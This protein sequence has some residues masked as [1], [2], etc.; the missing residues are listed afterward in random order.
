MSLAIYNLLQQGYL[1]YSSDINTD[2]FNTTHDLELVYGENENM[3]VGFSIEKNN[4]VSK[5]GILT[6]NVQEIVPKLK[7]INSTEVTINIPLNSLVYKNKNLPNGV[8]NVLYIAKYTKNISKETLYT[9][10]NGIISSIE[11]SS[12]N[13]D[14]YAVYNDEILCELNHLDGQINNN[15]SITINIEDL[16]VTKDLHLIVFNDFIKKSID[17]SDKELFGDMSSIYTEIS[18]DDSQYIFN[19]TSSY[20]A[21]SNCN[22]LFAYGTDENPYLHV[23][24]YDNDTY[25]TSSVTIDS[26]P[27]SPISKLQFTKDSS[28]LFVLTKQDPY[29]KIYTISNNTLN[30]GLSIGNELPTQEVADIAVTSNGSSIYLMSANIGTVIRRYTLSGNS[31]TLTSTRTLLDND[32]NIYR[33]MELNEDDSVIAL[34]SIDNGLIYNI[35]NG[36]IS[37]VNTTYIDTNIQIF[38]CFKFKWS[39]TKKYLVVNG[40]MAYYNTILN[41]NV[42]I[43]KKDGD[44]YKYLTTITDASD[45]YD[46][47]SIDFDLED[48]CMVLGGNQLLNSDFRTEYST[49]IRSFNIDNDVFTLQTDYFKDINSEFLDIFNGIGEVTS[50]DVSP[51]QIYI[52]ATSKTQPYLHIFSSSEKYI[53]SYNL[54]QSKIT[55]SISVDFVEDFKT[56]INTI[57][58]SHSYV[59]YTSSNINDIL[60]TNPSLAYS[61][62]RVTKDDD[63]LRVGMYADMNSNLEQDYSNKVAQLHFDTRNLNLFGNLVSAKLSF[64]IDKNTIHKRPRGFL[65]NVSNKLIVT[66][67][68]NNTS[69]YQAVSSSITSEIVSSASLDPYFY[70]TGNKTNYYDAIAIS[71]ESIESSYIDISNINQLGVTSFSLFIDSTYKSSNFSSSEL[72]SNGNIVSYS[73]YKEYDTFNTDYNTIIS[74][75]V[76]TDLNNEIIVSQ[77]TFP[78]FYT[79]TSKVYYHDSASQNIIN[80]TNTLTSSIMP[81]S[82]SKMAVSQDGQ[83]LIYDSGLM[84]QELTRS[85]YNENNTYHKNISRSNL[86]DRKVSDR[87]KLSN[88]NLYVLYEGFA[89]HDSYVWNLSNLTQYNQTDGKVPGFS[90]YSINGNSLSYYTLPTYSA[91]YYNGNFSN[92]SSQLVVLNNLDVPILF[93]L[94]NNTYDKL[95]IKSREYGMSQESSYITNGYFID[96][97][98]NIIFGMS[99]KDNQ[100]FKKNSASA[101]NFTVDVPVSSSNFIHTSN[102]SNH[103]L[104]G[105]IS[106]SEKH[107]KLYKHNYNNDTFELI[108]NPTEII[109]ESISISYRN[110]ILA[111]AHNSVDKIYIYSQSNDSFTKLNTPTSLPL[112]NMK[113]IQLSNDSKYMV[114]T[115]DTSPYMFVYKN[116]SNIY[117]L[118]E[119]DVTPTTEISS[120]GI[121]SV[122]NIGNGDFDVFLPYIYSGSANT[123]Y[124]Y[125][126]NSITDNVEFGYTASTGNRITNPHSINDS[127]YWKDIKWSND[128]SYFYMITMEKTVDGDET[129]GV[130]YFEPSYYT[131]PYTKQSGYAIKELRD[132]VSYYATPSSYKTYDSYDVALNHYP[133]KINSAHKLPEYV[134]T[135]NSGLNM[136]VTIYN[137]EFN[138][139]DDTTQYRYLSR[140]HRIY[141]N[142]ASEITNTQ[143]VEYKFSYD[144][145]YIYGVSEVSPYFTIYNRNSK[146]YNPVYIYSENQL[147]RDYNSDPNPKLNFYKYYPTSSLASI[148]GYKFTNTNNDFVVYGMGISETSDPIEAFSVNTSSYHY[149]FTKIDNYIDTTQLQGKTVI[150]LSY[151]SDDNR[152][153]ALCNDKSNIFL[154]Y[155]TS[156]ETGYV[157]N[158]TINTIPIKSRG[159]YNLADANIS[160]D[161]SYAVLC[162]YGNTNTIHTYQINDE[163][164]VTELDNICNTIDRVTSAD[165]S[166]TGSF[167][168]N[169][170]YNDSFTN[171]TSGKGVLVLSDINGWLEN[172][173]VLLQRYSSSFTTES[174]SLIATSSYNLYQSNVFDYRFNPINNLLNEKFYSFSYDNKL[175]SVVSYKTDCEGNQ[176]TT[177]V[178]IFEY[179][180]NENKWDIYESYKS[181]TSNILSLDYKPTSVSYTKFHPSMPLLICISYG[182]NKGISVYKFKSYFDP[183]DNPTSDVPGIMELVYKGILPSDYNGILVSNIVF[184]NDGKYMILHSSVGKIYGYKITWENKRTPI[185]TELDKGYTEDEIDLGSKYSAFYNRDI[186]NGNQQVA[187]FINDTEFVMPILQS[188]SFY[189]G[190]FDYNGTNIPLQASS[191]KNYIFYIDENDT[192]QLK[193]ETVEPYFINDTLPSYYNNQY[194]S[195][196]INNVSLVD[197]FNTSLNKDYIFHTA[198]YQPNSDLPDIQDAYLVSGSRILYRHKA[199]ENYHI[200]EFPKSNYI[201]LDLEYQPVTEPT[202]SINATSYGYIEYSSSNVNDIFDATSSIDYYIYSQSET[203]K[204]GLSYEGGVYTANVGYISFNT[205]TVAN[206]VSPTKVRLVFDINE[207]SYSYKPKTFPN[208]VDN[209]LNL[210]FYNYPFAIEDIKGLISTINQAH[211]SSYITYIEENN[212]WIRPIVVNTK[213]L[214]SDSSSNIDTQF[215]YPDTE[216][217]YTVGVTDNGKFYVDI[218][219]DTL[220]NKKGHTNILFY[221]DHLYK[222]QDFDNQVLTDRSLSYGLKYYN[223][224]IINKT[225]IERPKHIKTGLNESVIVILSEDQS[226]YSFYRSYG[227]DI[228]TN[229]FQSFIPSINANSTYIHLSDSSRYLSVCD[230]LV[231]AKVFYRTDNSYKEIPIIYANID[232]PVYCH[233]SDDSNYLLIVQETYPNIILGIQ[234]YSDRVVFNF[235]DDRVVE[236]S[237][238]GVI[239]PYKAVDM[240]NNVIVIGTNN[241]VLVYKNSS[242]GYSKDIMTFVTTNYNSAS[243]ISITKL[244]TNN[245]LAIVDENTNRLF[246][247]YISGFTVTEIFDYTFNGAVTDILFL[248]NN[249]YIAVSSVEDPYITF[250]EINGSDVSL[251]N[252]KFDIDI[253]EP[254]Y[255]M[256][257]LKSANKL[258]LG[259]KDNNFELEVSTGYSINRFNGINDLPTGLG[260][261]VDFSHNDKFMI[262][263][264]EQSPYITVYYV[265]DT[266]Y[267]KISNGNFDI[268]PSSTARCAAFSRDNNYLLVGTEAAPYLHIYQVNDN[269]ENTTFTSVSLPSNPF[270]SFIINIDFSYNGNYVIFAT[271]E[272]GIL[273]YSYSNGTLGTAMTI[274]IPVTGYVSETQFSPNDNF[275]G[276]A[277]DNSPYVRFYSHSNGIL[278]KLS[279]PQTIPTAKARDIAFTEDGV[280]V[281]INFR[282]NQGIIAYKYNGTKF[283]S[284]NILSETIGSGV[285]QEMILYNDR[286]LITVIEGSSPYIKTY[287]QTNNIYEPLYPNPFTDITGDAFGISKSNNGKFIAIAHDSAPYITVYKVISDSLLLKS[288]DIKPYTYTLPDGDVKSIAISNEDDY[289]AI[290]SSQEDYI[291]LYNSI[292]GNITRLKS[293]DSLPTG[294]ATSIDFSKNDKYI[295]IGYQTS[296]YINVYKLNKSNHNTTLLNINY[297]YNNEINTVAF[298]EGN[299]YLAIGNNTAPYIHI[300]EVNNIIDQFNIILNE[301]ST[302]P[303]GIVNSIAFSDN[304][305]YMAV[306]YNIP[307]YLSVYSV[308]RNTNSFTKLETITELPI[309]N[310]IDV[311][312]S[313][314]SE[315]LSVTHENSPFVSLYQVNS[316]TDEFTK[317]EDPDTL[318]INQIKSTTFISNYLY[319]NSDVAPYNHLYKL[320][321]YDKPTNITDRLSIPNDP[322]ITSEISSD[323]NYLVVGTNTSQTLKVYSLDYSYTD[324]NNLLIYELNGDFINHHKISFDVGDDTSLDFLFDTPVYNKIQNITPSSIG[325]VSFNTSDLNDFINNNISYTLNKASDGSVN[326]ENSIGKVGNSYVGS[327]GMFSVDITK[328]KSAQ[329]VNSM[330]IKLDITP[331]NTSTTS[332]YYA[333]TGNNKYYLYAYV[334]NVDSD[335]VNTV[336]SNILS[337]PSLY[338]VGEIDLDDQFVYQSQDSVDYNGVNYYDKSIYIDLD[339]SKLTYSN[340]VT[341]FSFHHYIL[342]KN[343]FAAELPLESNIDSLFSFTMTEFDSISMDLYLNFVRGI[344]HQLNK[345]DIV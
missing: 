73:L 86:T 104:V 91:Y 251:K 38:E 102:I 22:K 172:K 160:S 41:G 53:D 284:D 150:K 3:E 297:A 274:N 169:T 50:C 138:S 313:S 245:Y 145:R 23:Y 56:T 210:V 130:R 76:E 316:I 16:D 32:E 122:L 72:N 39:T 108:P 81:G 117:E 18:V 134:V 1:K 290:A 215:S 326:F 225:Y 43:L 174:F 211:R 321:D 59:D 92:D 17:I 291:A 124:T 112:G 242:K 62:Y 239:N 107:V 200:I 68:I 15:L 80:I 342:D 344:L 189:D 61:R 322:S 158:Q 197:I 100:M 154:Y 219:D 340:N 90:L 257:F 28:K 88:D 268:L 192:I 131:N 47:K 287:V 203:I 246:V 118:K 151:T 75:I 31:Y 111:F 327:I 156:S 273:G 97:S 214:E 55:A 295:A 283:E 286:T 128:N 96:N 177:D 52:S 101:S 282:Q 9:D 146:P 147:I 329:S 85:I 149:E 5:V 179:I 222:Q 181:D 266:E 51:N 285:G 157:Y 345:K 8:S 34:A 293:P 300:Y 67:L 161:G 221:I 308:D 248:E 125:K 44:S 337:N 12:I 243:N 162:A 330:N 256:S 275:V 208:G 236:N 227:G 289:V 288:F 120:F 21:Y 237:I 307:P 187:S 20:S 11:N 241:G 182:I 318:P 310:A 196:N 183:Q 167:I 184:S 228:H 129:R 109:S 4:Y 14:T 244:S 148:D 335:N 105:D 338:K 170:R 65:D 119:L 178:D 298:D 115:T 254:I 113:D 159:T 240:R 25:L 271:S 304:N 224:S 139:Y 311:T 7:S 13:L 66:K 312:F 137:D 207:D 71:T 259:A 136:D 232:R 63:V 199:F 19:L 10:L 57:Y 301:P 253:N 267:I 37:D 269:N 218:E 198:L 155:Y 234:S 343:T 58:S 45:M 258:L 336:I 153:L 233:I 190:D 331:E 260:T 306:G 223:G 127:Y 114:V 89:N 98:K 40:I 171:K 272:Q 69:N 265:T 296:P 213:D 46:I 140:T 333:S 176:S 252:I 185:I 6:F 229:V 77:E 132:R 261:A 281:F 29:Y 33:S 205:Y 27:T 164:V 135:R 144:D 294:Q 270:T 278:T 121:S 173:S 94:E 30:D 305:S 116:T 206:N 84:N 262:V 188:G 277:M 325:Y 328:F 264:H 332:S 186:L 87:T 280:N 279:D 209:Y 314:G 99:S 292:D 238:T 299:K 323:G 217:N 24:S 212:L 95:Y 82:M 42:H 302:L 54:L 83:W 276:V 110:N 195:Q 220:I 235:K 48:T 204:S 255:A 175:L 93:D 49:E 74:S 133:N 191:V 36:N 303:T 202:I 250:F 231:S 315:Y 334:G 226:V 60:D 26:K 317:I 126:L 165:I 2:F 64:H 142:S 249:K 247:F 163:N 143:S 152:L 166:I 168:P 309:G 106:G 194:L 180:E 78:T 339:K 103:I 193:Y 324:F 341:I 123:L 35:D 319:L 79:A 320:N 141:Y 70:F 201:S 216:L 230:Y 263:S